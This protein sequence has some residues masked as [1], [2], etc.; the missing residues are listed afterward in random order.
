MSDKHKFWLDNILDKSIFAIIKGRQKVQQPSDNG[1]G[2]K[3]D[4]DA[5]Q[6]MADVSALFMNEIAEGAKYVTIQERTDED[7]IEEGEAD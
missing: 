7:D 6:L 1:P 5:K 2:T 3:A 4:A